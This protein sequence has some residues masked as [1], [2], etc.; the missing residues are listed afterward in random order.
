[1]RK[2]VTV[3]AIL[4]VLIPVCGCI[5]G[6]NTITEAP[7]TTVAPTTVPPNVDTTPILA[8]ELQAMLV[9]YQEKYTKESEQVQAMLD[10][11]Q[12]MSQE[13]IPDY[14][15]IHVAYGRYLTAMEDYLWDEPTRYYN[16]K[17]L[18]EH[19]TPTVDDL[20]EIRKDTLPFSPGIGYS[21]GSINV[22]GEGYNIVT[23]N[24]IR[25]I[26]S[27]GLDG[28]DVREELIGAFE[29]LEYVVENYLDAIIG[30]VSYDLSEILVR[31]STYSDILIRD[32]N[33]YCI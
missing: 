10:E 8:S 29:H 28:Q 21:F 18:L 19:T 22:V 33:P 31:Q 6:D 30:Y 17:V 20:L 4:M 25:G 24:Q 32:C 1:M 2:G 23:T 27:E 26:I 13:L 12:A 14:E 11:L 9:E 3:L 5:G 15:A 16:A 7:T